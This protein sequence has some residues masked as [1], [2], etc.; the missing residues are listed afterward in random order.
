MSVPP[1]PAAAARPRARRPILWDVI[2]EHLEEAAFLW[3]QRERSLR[4]PDYTLA[5][6]AEGDE[7]RL[8]AHVDGL[9]IGG[10]PVAE[11][12]LI[13]AVRGEGEPGQVGPAALALL[14]SRERDFTGALLDLLPEGPEDSRS[15]LRTAFEWSGREGLDAALLRA[16]GR[17]EP[18]TQAFLLEVLSFRQ[19]ALGDVLERLSVVED[20]ALF[21][22]ALRAARFAARPWA[23]ALV[24]GALED[25]RPRVRSAAL[26]TG[27]VL[28][29]RRAWK[30]CA[31]L[32]REPSADGRL[33]RVALALGGEAAEAQLLIKLLEDDALRVEATWALGFSGR[34]VAADAVKETLAQGGGDR[35]AGE[36]FALITGLP[37]ERFLEP[38]LEPGEEDGGDEAEGESVTEE[39]PRLPGPVLPP[40]KVQVAAVEAWWQETRPRLSERHRYLRGEPLTQ[41]LLV[42]ALLRG[43]MSERPSWALE[44]AVRSRGACFL[45]LS[46]LSARQYRQLEAARALNLG[47]M[48]RGF[49]G[50]LTQ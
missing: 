3:R 41:E 40:G 29:L 7:A 44:L 10:L 27:L 35:L 5:D 34:R 30:A 48:P 32:C 36:A 42:D 6:V 43:P 1:N 38:A 37:L 2:R 15:A 16:L 24:Q 9:E 22:A 11:R 49:D 31:S 23:V 21:A 39:N 33:A 12:L 28:G 18:P 50:L 13:P 45:E 46:A 19:V 47:P 14:A 17:A 8:L 26:E 20:P 25:T 4:S